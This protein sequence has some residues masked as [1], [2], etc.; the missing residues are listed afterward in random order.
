MDLLRATGVGRDANRHHYT[1]AETA[2]ALARPVVAATLD[3]LRLRR[4]H[5]A[6]AGT[7]TWMLDGSTGTI[8]WDDGP[9]T[10]TLSFDVRD[11]TFEVRATPAGDCP[12]GI[13][14]EGFAI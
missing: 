7:C 13:T 10:A 6:F 14:W 4:D 1:P 5:P 3:G 12:T 11:A 2:T 8:R 9:H